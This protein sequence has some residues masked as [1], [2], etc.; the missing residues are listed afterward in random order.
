MGTASL[1][2]MDTV[3]TYLCDT[4]YTGESNIT[5]TC[6][7]NGMWSG[8]DLTCTRKLIFNGGLVRKD[9]Y[10]YVCHL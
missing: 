4:G 7:S 3:A 5:K 10:M 8:S 9:M 6:G 2:P 1:R